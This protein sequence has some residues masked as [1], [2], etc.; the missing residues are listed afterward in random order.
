MGYTAPPTFVDT[1]VLYAADLNQY[2]RDNMAWL[3]ADRPRWSL[4]GGTLSAGVVGAT[5]THTTGNSGDWEN[6]NWSSTE[7]VDTGNCHSG[8]N[9][10]VTIPTAGFYVFGAVC[11]WDGNVTGGRGLAISSAASS[12]TSIG[13]TEYVQDFR[14]AQNNGPAMPVSYGTWL[15]ASTTLYVA[16]YQNSGTTSNRTVS[17]LR[18]WGCRMAG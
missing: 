3:E 8:T 7:P 1:N 10:F 11:A 9:A 18:F 4:T 15:A 6:P 14:S 13:G 16:L 12:G 2:L 5:F 17:N